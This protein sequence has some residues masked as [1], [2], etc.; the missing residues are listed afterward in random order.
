MISPTR[1]PD[2]GDAS[3]V[4]PG[5]MQTFPDTVQGPAGLRLGAT[6]LRGLWDRPSTRFFHDGRGRSLREA[7]ATP[8]H[9]ALAP[10]DTGRNERDGV[11]DTHGGTSQLDKYQLED[12]MNFLM[13]L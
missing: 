1:A 5:F 6:P 7:L 11:F 9:P 2:G 3:R 8:G 12:L 13:T 10:G 4:T